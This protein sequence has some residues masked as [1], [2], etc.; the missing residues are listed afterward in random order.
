MGSVF[1]FLR[2]LSSLFFLYF[3]L[4]TRTFDM[5]RGTVISLNHPLNSFCFFG[6]RQLASSAGRGAGERMLHNF[7]IG[8]QPR[9]FAPQ[10][11]HT[12][13]P[14]FQVNY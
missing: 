13:Y 5:R 10:Y 9:H 2:F 11:L 4:Q 7:Y 1:T 6:C 3:L 12:E 14:N 8:E